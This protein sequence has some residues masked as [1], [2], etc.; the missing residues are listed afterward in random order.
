MSVAVEEQRI[1]SLLGRVAAVE[2]VARSLPVG[3]E[4]RTRLLEVT[5]EALAEAGTIR[6]VIAARLLGLAEKTI[7]AW[8]SQCVISV[9]D[10]SPSPRLL[11]DLA[12][13]HEISQLDQLREHGKDRDLL[14]EVW[15]RLNDAALIERADLQESIGQMR[16]G[17]GRVV[18]PITEKSRQR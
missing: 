12:S 1:R 17:Q 13:V 15:R 10:E 5:S 11:L 8:A 16:Q 14:A 2:D 3:D 6:P 4:R 9:A 18:R 7:R